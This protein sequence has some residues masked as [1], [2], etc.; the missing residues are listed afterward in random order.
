MEID[1]NS[2]SNNPLGAVGNEQR[3]SLSETESELNQCL[4]NMFSGPS[5]SLESAFG[6]LLRM[7]QEQSAEHERLKDSQEKLRSD[8]DKQIRQLED[9]H[10]SAVAIHGEEQ[11]KY[12]E[13]LS[14]LQS[15][16][17]QLASSQKK[18][19]DELA[20]T[21]QEVKVSPWGSVIVFSVGKKKVTI[22]LIFYGTFHE[23]A[24]SAITILIDKSFYPLNLT[25][26]GNGI[27]FPRF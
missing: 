6:I 22:Y 8:H 17:E 19:S 10:H 25:V 27:Q 13:T 26:S 14:S 12:H 11:Q 21:K 24:K 5:Q 2:N 3:T 15:K 16:Q 9:L 20:E 1:G 7:I 4:Q 18:L 23:T